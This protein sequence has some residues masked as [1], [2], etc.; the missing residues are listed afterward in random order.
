MSLIQPSKR[1]IGVVGLVESFGQGAI[2][3]VPSTRD[4]KKARRIA[5]KSS[6]VFTVSS[7]KSPPPI[8][9]E[10]EN[11]THSVLNRRCADSKEIIVFDRPFDMPTIV[12][13][14]RDTPMPDVSVKNLWSFHLVKLLWS[15]GYSLAQVV[16]TFNAMPPTLSESIACMFASLHAFGLSQ[17]RQIAP[18]AP[19]RTHES[20][21]DSVATAELW[22][23]NQVYGFL[24]V[25]T[26]LSLAVNRRLIFH[27]WA[28][29]L[30]MSTP[31]YG[32]TSS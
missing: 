15:M 3:D 12:G 27:G 10:D 25:R 13:F 5:M 20:L 8:K 19:P 28:R 21:M 17:P 18:E 9:N 24:E 22:E 16:S 29:L 7:S 1:R 6:K 30:L 4:L 26:E 31:V 11:E 32:N 14:R 23:S 2:V